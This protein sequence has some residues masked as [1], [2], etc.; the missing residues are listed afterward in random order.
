MLFEGEL[1][2]VNVMMIVLMV[3]M[4]RCVRRR[5]ALVCVKRR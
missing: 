3:M 1:R 4:S 2:L 5:S